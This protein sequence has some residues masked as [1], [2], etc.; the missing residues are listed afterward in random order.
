MERAGWHYPSGD[1]RASDADRDRAVSELSEAFQVGRITADEFDERSGQA[2]S[3]RT[4][5][6][7]TALLADL[8]VQRAVSTGPTAVERAHRVIATRIALG[9]SAV[10]AFIFASASA[11]AALSQGPTVQQ[12]EMIRDMMLRQGMPVPQSFLVRPPFDWAGT[13]APG[14]I[15]V[16]LIALMIYLGV[17]LS[18]ADRT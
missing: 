2:L 13:I 3:A 14:A 18:R 6:E 8:P 4:G 1:L 5:K 12:R 10:A 11:A 15:A 7:L 16:L 9:T 17:R